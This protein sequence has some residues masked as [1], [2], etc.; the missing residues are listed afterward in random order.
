M[1]MLISILFVVIV[2]A[3][4]A[5]AAIY[6]GIYKVEDDSNV[7]HIRDQLEKVKDKVVDQFNG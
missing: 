2:V 5:G 6:F 4:I 1:N 7:D 3:A